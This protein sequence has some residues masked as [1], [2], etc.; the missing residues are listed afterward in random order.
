VGGAIAN[1]GIVPVIRHDRK[2]PSAW[3]RQLLVAF[4]AAFRHTPAPMPDRIAFNEFMREMT[5]NIDGAT[6]QPEHEEWKDTIERIHRTDQVHT[7]T[8]ET[9]YYFLEV[10]PP[11]WMSGPFFAFAEGQEE[12]TIY[13]ERNG[14]YF[15]RRLTH[16]QSMRFCETSGLSKSYGS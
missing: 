15:G 13:F 2:C 4:P 10:L 16:E 6:E 12:L 11:Q 8:E 7:V 3:A 1:M 5:S 9:Y 14:E